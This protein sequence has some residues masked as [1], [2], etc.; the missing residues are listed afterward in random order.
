MT[1]LNNHEVMFHVYGVCF[2]VLLLPL[3]F[4]YDR[5]ENDPTGIHLDD[6]IHSVDFKI[7]V[8]ASIAAAFPITADLI[9][10]FIAT[11]KCHRTKQVIPRV[12]ICATLLGTSFLHMYFTL[13]L[14]SV[15]ATWVILN[16]R[17]V[18]CSTVLLYQCFIRFGHVVTPAYS[19]LTLFGWNVGSIIRCHGGNLSITLQIGKY[20]I[21]VAIILSAWGLAVHAQMYLAGNLKDWYSKWHRTCF[22]LLFITYVSTGVLTALL[23]D[24]DMMY[25]ISP[26]E[27]LIY[28]YNTMVFLIM[29]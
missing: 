11:V 21:V 27:M 20:T 3:L 8:Y 7:M 26:E 25:R 2:V 28:S 5:D 23:T 10:N 24:R 14:G 6:M 18:M 22:E 4:F 12:A 29:I 16:I 17:T 1:L 15:Y 19:Y 9:I 13:Y